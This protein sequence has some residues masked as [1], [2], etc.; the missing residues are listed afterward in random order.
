MFSDDDRRD[1]ARLLRGIKDT[2]EGCG[3]ELCC[4]L[5]S[6]ISNIAYRCSGLC[7]ECEV[8][9]LASLADLIEPEPERTARM[10]YDEVHC[11]YVCTSCGERTPTGMYEAVADDD[12]L[13]LKQMRY[14]PACGTRLEGVVR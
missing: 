1:V 14:C 11:D 6:A 5:W 4:D 9:V 8:V 10:E 3:H 13:L 12:R 2:R 7:D